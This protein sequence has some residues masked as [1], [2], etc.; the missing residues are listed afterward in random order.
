MKRPEQKAKV[1][2]SQLCISMQFLPQ[3]EQISPLFSAPRRKKTRLLRCLF[4]FPRK[5]RRFANYFCALCPVFRI[6]GVSHSVIM[7]VPMAAHLMVILFDFLRPQI[8]GDTFQ[9]V[10][11]RSKRSLR[12]FFAFWKSRNKRTH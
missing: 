10:T 8:T 7:I 9:S 1:T 12:C 3:F 5:S 11:Q 6:S 4:F 2:D